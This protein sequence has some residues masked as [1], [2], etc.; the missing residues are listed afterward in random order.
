[1]FLENNQIPQRTTIERMA[2]ELGMLSDMQV[3]FNCIMKL[4]YFCLNMCYNFLYNFFKCSNVLYEVQNFTLCFDAS[5]QEGVHF[6]V[7]SI[8]TT[9]SS[10]LLG[11]YQLAGIL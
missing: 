2:V 1:M 3:C 9:D 6:N 7:I 10:Y 4:I 5:T 11:L 8:T